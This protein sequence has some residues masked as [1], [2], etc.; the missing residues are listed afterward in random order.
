MSKSVRFVA[1]LSGVLLLISP[2]T[3]CFAEEGNSPRWDGFYTGLTAGYSAAKFSMSSR[4]SL[5]STG[6]NPGA[7][8]YWNDHTN[9]GRVSATGSGNLFSNDTMAGAVFG[10]NLR[11]GNSQL[12]GVELDLSALGANE[13]TTRATSYPSLLTRSPQTTFR[14]SAENFGALAIKYGTLVNDTLFYVKGG[15]AMSKISFSSNFSD[16][17]ASESNAR[18]ETKMGWMFGLGVEHKVQNNVSIKAEYIH[19]NFGSISNTS[20]NLS[21]PGINYIN[22]P[23]QSSLQVRLDILR[24]GVNMSF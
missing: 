19:A 14:T 2:V 9:A 6:Y 22:Q 11:L 3:M 17:V 16:G 15:P 21:Q 8:T 18:S 4:T 1:L 12:T 5:T 13:T 10:Y 20:N 24:I 7:G 23:F